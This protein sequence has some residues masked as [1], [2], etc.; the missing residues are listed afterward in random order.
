VAAEKYQPFLDSL[1][2]K[3]MKKDLTGKIRTL[4]M[5]MKQ[6]NLPDNSFDLVWSEASAYILGFK[7]ALQDWKKLLKPNGYLVVTECCWTSENR[8]K[9]VA[10]FWDEEYPGMLTVTEARSIAEEA[11]FG[12]VGRLTLPESD[13]ENYYSPLKKRAE[14][15]E[16]GAGPEME[17]VIEHIRKEIDIRDKFNSDYDYVAFILK[18][19]E[20]TY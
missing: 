8:S 11:G 12:V 16:K 17:Q 10:D 4:N 1:D 20:K 6:L 3:A 7:K 15:L 14:V 19:P 5:S 2:E 13:W 18:L 9:E